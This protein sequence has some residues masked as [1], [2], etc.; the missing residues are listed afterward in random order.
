MGWQLVWEK[1]A[2]GGEWGKASGDG[3]MSSLIL[4]S[5]S[6]CQL[7]CSTPSCSPAPPLPERQRGRRDWR[8]H[9]RVCVDYFVC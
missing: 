1:V 2:I 8:V 9:L 7:V 4:L 6:A 5:L 3:G